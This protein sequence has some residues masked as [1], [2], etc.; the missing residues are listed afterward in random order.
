M[1]R[2]YTVVYT[3]MGK[4]EV[5]LR[6]AAAESPKAAVAAVEK[7]EGAVLNS[8]KVFVGRQRCVLDELGP[9]K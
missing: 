8:F 6:T 3:M 2:D 4:M 9:T 7:I 1:R 5:H